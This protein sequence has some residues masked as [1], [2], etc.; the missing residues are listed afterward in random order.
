MK[1]TFITVSGPA[2]RGL[3]Y[4]DNYIKETYGP[5]LDLR[6]YYA[7]A[8][9][10][11][12]KKQRMMADIRTSDLVFT[13][14]MSSP[15]STAAAVQ[16][17]MEQYTG[18][19]ISYGRI[20]R[21]YMKMDEVHTPEKYE[22]ICRYFRLASGENM[23]HLL[24]FLLKEYAGQSQITQQSEAQE[25]PEAAICDPETVT[26]YESWEDYW[27]E[28]EWKENGINIVLLFYGR[29]YPVDYFSVAAQ[30]VKRLSGAGNVFPVA[31]SG[32]GAVQE[33]IL[34]EIL[35]GMGERRAD[36][37]VNTMAFCLSAGPM[38]G[39]KACGEQLLK[40]LD[41]PHIHPY[42]MTR[43][44]EEQ[45]REAVQGSSISE[46]LI[47]VMLPEMDG[48]VDTIPVAARK[49]PVYNP[50][51][52]VE[53]DELCLIE[54][55]ADMLTQR[56]CAYASL[57]RKKNEEKKIA[58]ICYNYPPGE[59]NLFGGSFLDTFESVAAMTEALH[60]EGYQVE[61]MTSEELM[62]QF[63]QDG[64]V[65]SG[66][67]SSSE[68]K[69]LHFTRKAYEKN[70][71]RKDIAQVWGEAPGEIMADLAGNFLIP[72][73]RNGNLFIGLQPTRGVHEQQEMLCHDKGL[74]PHHQYAAFYQYLREEFQADAII[75]V[76][77]HG[78]LE[79]LPGKECGM[80]GDCYPDA[81]LGPVP[82]FYLYYCGN[83]AE[84]TIAKRRSGATLISYQPPV[85]VPGGLY[86]EY[87]KLSAMLDEYHH[88]L[89]LS[90]QSAQEV[91]ENILTLTKKLNLPEELE[92]TEMELY[93]MNRS[94]IPSGLHCFG[95]SFT[96]E[97]AKTYARAMVSYSRD[98]HESL[99]SIAAQARG[100]DEEALLET[101]D[102]KTLQACEEAA[103]EY[104]EQYFR[105]DPSVNM[106][107][108]LRQKLFNAL[109][110]AKKTAEQ[111]SKTA[112]MDSLLHVLSGGYL[113]AKLAGDIYRST[114]ILPSGYN[115]YQFD[116]RQVP[117][118]TAYSRGIRIAEETLKLYQ[119]EH[120]GWPEQ[121]A[122]VLWGIETSKTQGETFSQILGYLGIRPAKAGGRQKFELIPIEEM[123]HP[124][125]DV[126]VNICG[127]FRDL[128]PN[129]IGLLD[130]LFH[131]AAQA[132]ETEEQNY[133]KKHASMLREQ[134]YKEGYEAEEAEEFSL[135]RVFG[136]QEGGYGTGVN[137]KIET[138]SWEAEE[139]L[140]NQFMS[141][142]CHVYT[143]KSRG[144]RAVGLYR[145]NLKRVELVS[146]IRASQEYQLT[147]LDHYYEYFGGLSK[148]VELVRG[149]KAVMYITDTTGDRI[150]TERA[151]HS[152][153]RGI[154]T[155]VLNPKW[156]D[157]LLQHKYHGAQKI[158]KRFENVMGLAATTGAVDQWTYDSLYETYA[159]DEE[160]RERM[161]ENNPHAY[162]NILR[163]MLEYQQRGY[164]EASPEQLLLLR[165]LFLETEGMIEEFGE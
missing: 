141:S 55:R 109:E 123:T 136:P 50:E 120:G 70:P 17:A 82:H 156:I 108:E 139:E 66:R 23:L 85:F 65:N 118:Q 122:V 49:E 88:A 116:R 81:L 36:V 69:M 125:I 107:P 22:Q 97:E 161:R 145:E 41:V 75:H 31:V 94:L 72:G 103:D 153:R 146:Q 53:L 4:A 84:S 162:L 155:R 19:V 98:G 140:G 7:T 39:D 159:E 111:V 80:S 158:E 132:D 48:A 38:G 73:I 121:T 27:K 6:L 21:E 137:K 154:R 79:F 77:T 20:C 157:G 58:V 147:D 67:Y 78:T 29:T 100:L 1:L 63:C 150:L 62:E 93:R 33:G 25:I 119:K 71:R 96:E 9:Y 92:E 30:L 134:L 32:S 110:Y 91:K 3:V 113:E 130:E 102:V 64:C 101:Q 129:L 37:L 35:D 15:S 89:A 117:T 83:P 34:S 163:Q 112:E 114:Q 10:S 68:E 16:S 143:R 99:Q 149:K 104:F 5:I 152:I 12:A 2:I 142:L 13:D 51:F 8:E 105:G 44:T 133:V 90:P 24:C 74:P 128:F 131:M 164:W 45:W 28:K 26:Y 127:F 46:L 52:D 124:R 14:L 57:G 59:D 11:E 76:G 43:R 165:Q 160:L 86:D 148:S 40:Q 151:E 106:D 95:R 87:A 144:K 135:A 42:F 138:K 56:I 60:G 115:L 126:T 54:E 47:S 61:P 18:R